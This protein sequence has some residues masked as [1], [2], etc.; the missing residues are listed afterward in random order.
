MSFYLPHFLVYESIY[1]EGQDAH[2]ITDTIRRSK[3][4][5]LSSSSSAAAAA[6]FALAFAFSLT[7]IAVHGAEE[8][9]HRQLG[10]LSE[11]TISIQVSFM[12]IPY[13]S[14]YSFLVFVHY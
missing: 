8:N 10:Q 2:T 14:K 13:H 9:G 6:A 5:W 12:A 11:A 3:M 7:V 4:G 1:R